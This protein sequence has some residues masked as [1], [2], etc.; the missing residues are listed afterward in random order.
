MTISTLRM[1]YPDNV[2]IRCVHQ[3]IINGI[4]DVAEQDT[5][6]SHM[7]AKIAECA[8]ELRDMSF[9]DMKNIIKTVL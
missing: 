8:T 4:N 7:T 6:N 3:I 5:T 1:K 2:I 9:K